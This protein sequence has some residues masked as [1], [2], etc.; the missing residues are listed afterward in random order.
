MGSP[1]VLIKGDGSGTRAPGPGPNRVGPWGQAAPHGLIRQERRG[2]A[3]KPLSG[4]KFGGKDSPIAQTNAGRGFREGLVSPL[5]RQDCR[6]TRS[7]LCPTNQ[8]HH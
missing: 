1:Y 8:E 7:H 6:P 4:H 5:P 3:S 2:R